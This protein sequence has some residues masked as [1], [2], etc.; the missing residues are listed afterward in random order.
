[1]KVLCWIQKRISDGK[2][3][4]SKYC[5]TKKNLR[6]KIKK[7]DNKTKVSIFNTMISSVFLYN[8]EI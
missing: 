6:K 2:G 8:S 7:L 3:D 1:M 4:L 5:M